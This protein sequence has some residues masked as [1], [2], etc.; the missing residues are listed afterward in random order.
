MYWA[1]PYYYTLWITVITGLLQGLHMNLSFTFKCLFST[2]CRKIINNNV[3]SHVSRICVYGEITDLVNTTHIFFDIDTNFLFSI[4]MFFLFSLDNI[5]TINNIYKCFW[6]WNSIVIVLPCFGTK[7]RM[8][9]C[10]FLLTA[11]PSFILQ[12]DI[13]S[14]IWSG[15]T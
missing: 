8:E 13:I 10:Q 15:T 6:F 11:S 9:V 7:V 4:N 14:S 3:S 5:T 12:G 1:L 2:F